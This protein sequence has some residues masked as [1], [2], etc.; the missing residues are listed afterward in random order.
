M[1][2]SMRAVAQEDPKGQS[3]EHGR[4]RELRRTVPVLAELGERRD[5][6]LR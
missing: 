5:G 3:A 4:G 1:P 6:R 2:C